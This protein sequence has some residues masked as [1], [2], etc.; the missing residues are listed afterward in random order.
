MKFSNYINESSL[1]RIWKHIIGDNTFGILSAFFVSKDKEE[2]E[3]NH[4]SL[5]KDVRGLGYGFIEMKG[6]YTYETGEITEEKSLFIPKISKNEITKLAKKYNQESFIFKNEE[7][8]YLINTKTGKTELNF[9]KSSN[10]ML[11]MSSDEVKDLFSQLM[12]GSHRGKK[13]AFSVKEDSF[14]LD[15]EREYQNHI[16]AYNKYNKKNKWINWI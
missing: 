15:I 16:D 14:F 1:S 12:K 5:K 7:G 9:D 8:F 6:G 2:N 13:F 10:K 4:L 3:S 11:R